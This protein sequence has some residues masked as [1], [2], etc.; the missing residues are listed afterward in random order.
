MGTQYRA[1]ITSTPVPQEIEYNPAGTQ[2]PY[3]VDVT[4]RN[5][6]AFYVGSLPR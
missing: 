2:A 4:I 1:T 5:N 3:P 6:S